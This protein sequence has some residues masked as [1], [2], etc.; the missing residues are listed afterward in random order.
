MKQYCSLIIVFSLIFMTTNFCVAQDE[1]TSTEDYVVERLKGFEDLEKDSFKLWRDA[2]IQ[3][4]V[5]SDTLQVRNEYIK[6]LNKELKKLTNK[7][8][9]REAE[10]TKLKNNAAVNQ[11]KQK[12]LNQKEEKIKTLQKDLEGK[13]A[14]ENEIGNLKKDY[15][16]LVSK[17][18]KLE[19]EKSDLS[20]EV[21]E[22]KTQNEEKS[23]ALKK[24][25]D[26][27]R[28]ML[29]SVRS[30]LDK[31]FEE[32]VF[33]GVGDQLNE[34]QN[35]LDLLKN[36]EESQEIKKISKQSKEALTAVDLFDRAKVILN[37]SFDSKKNKKL[38]ADLE[39]F[40]PSSIKI[41][42]E[43]SKLI[44]LLKNYCSISE[45]I[46]DGIN[47]SF[48][49]KQKATK[50]GVINSV[51]NENLQS[52]KSYTYLKRQL[53]AKLKDIESNNNPIQPV[54]CEN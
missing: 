25:K 38:V 47:S 49:W 12:S 10:I 40:S 6:Y 7:L 28:D 16:E 24:F 14:L 2:L 44:P 51:I 39:K 29:L 20:A 13:V 8:D 3:V 32:G 45:E 50:E 48:K 31:I 26:L 15:E 19:Q 33:Y 35:K 4:N 27:Q 54:N 17:S 42:N 37:N 30:N 41:E 22:L 21:N 34:I 1:N 53:E 11:V 18:E 46:Y 36:I 52:L 5:L 9:N 23:N 43:K